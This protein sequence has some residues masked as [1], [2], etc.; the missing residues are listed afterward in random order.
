MIKIVKKSDK[1]T[2]RSLLS[3]VY[4]KLLKT[5][6]LDNAI[7]ELTLAKPSW[8]MSHYTMLFKYGKQT[9]D[10]GGVFNFSLVYFSIFCGRL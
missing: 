1:L 5:V 10:L 2:P 6:S 4:P 7:R 9:R 8:V 3:T